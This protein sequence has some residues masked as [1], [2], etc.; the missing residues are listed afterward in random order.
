MKI[1]C[2]YSKQNTCTTCKHQAY[3]TLLRPTNKNHSRLLSEINYWLN[4]LKE[5]NENISQYRIILQAIH[6]HK[7]DTTINVYGHIEYAPKQNALGVF[8]RKPEHVYY[9]WNY[10][11]L[12]KEKDKLMDHI[13]LLNHKELNMRRILERRSSNGNPM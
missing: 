9:G 10:G 13:R 3:C 4:K 1:N 8:I 12:E 11:R 7:Y 2:N 5:T 6:N